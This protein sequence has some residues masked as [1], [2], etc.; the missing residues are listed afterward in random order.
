MSIDL[1]THTNFSDGSLSPEALIDIAIEKKIK[2]LA[3]TDHDEVGAIHPA[4]QYTKNKP[5]EIVPGVELSIEYKLPAQGHL[6]ILGLFIDY[7][8]KELKR[9]LD[10]LKHARYDRIKQ[11][12]QKINAM[13]YNLDF[14]E[15]EQSIGSGSAGRPHLARMLIEKGIVKN[16]RDAFGKFLSKGQPAHVPKKKLS[17]EAAIELIHQAGGLAIIAHPFSLGYETYP[18]MGREILKLKSMGL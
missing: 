8:N 16:I 13:G 12:V 17:A 4:I 7:Q 5:I 11:M 10:Q 1:H 14:D 3:I 9:I 15:L 18:E 6:H 2:A